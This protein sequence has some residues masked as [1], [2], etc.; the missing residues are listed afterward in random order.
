L[1][2]SYL[3]LFFSLTFFLH[4]CGVQPFEILREIAVNIYRVLRVDSPTH[5]R[6]DIR[7]FR[8]VKSNVN[9]PAP[10]ST[11]CHLARKCRN[12][13]SNISRELHYPPPQKEKRKGNAVAFF[14][15]H[16]TKM[17][18][19]QKRQNLFNGKVLIPPQNG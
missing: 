14:F 16:K 12:S 7:I 1:P 10:C 2:E 11:I 6:F 13:G 9:K 17:K 19:S 15:L 5:Y 18:S 3:L 4:P 8:S